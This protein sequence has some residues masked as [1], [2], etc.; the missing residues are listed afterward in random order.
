MRHNREKATVALDLLVAGV[1]PYVERELKAAYGDDWQRQARSSFRDNRGRN[2]QSDKPL[3]WDAHL[4]LT[5]MWDQWNR[6]F[7]DKLTH[8]DRSLVSELREYRN[9][10]AHQSEFDFDDTYRMLDSVERLLKSVGS[11]LARRVSREKRDLMRS[12]FI[13]EAKAAY[14]RSQLKKRLWQDLAIYFVCSAAIIM[15]IVPLFGFSAWVLSAFVVFVFSYLGYQRWHSHPPLIFGPHECGVCRRI[16]YGADCPY[17]D[18]S[19]RDPS[20][21][22]PFDSIDSVDP[23]PENQHEEHTPSNAGR[24]PQTVTSATKDE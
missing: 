15:V 23:I 5:V 1:G 10:W 19:R 21:F 20:L 14:R 16:I 6:A 12:R 8:S 18:H 13:A 9:Q 4:L 2:G 3:Q 24:L 11:P 22:A 17:C 7:R